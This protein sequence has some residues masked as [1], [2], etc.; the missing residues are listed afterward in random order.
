MIYTAAFDGLPADAQ[1]AIYRRLW[2]VLSGSD[3]DPKYV[4]LSTDDRRD[5][6]D[7]LGDTKVDLP[8]YFV[9]AP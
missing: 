6:I 7:I 4:R 8:P 2:H 1:A 9:S 5:I 3:A